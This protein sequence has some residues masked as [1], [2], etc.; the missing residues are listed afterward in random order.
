MLLGLN[1]KRLA[2]TA[3]VIGAIAYP[4]WTR[5]WTAWGSVISDIENSG[6]AILSHQEDEWAAAR[7]GVS[8]EQMRA[9]EIRKCEEHADNHRL[10][11]AAQQALDNVC[12]LR[13]AREL[14]PSI[15]KIWWLGIPRGLEHIGHWLIDAMLGSAVAAV[16]AY[17]GPGLLTNWWRWVRE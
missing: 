1:R 9:D 4:V 5:S 3:A 12:Y 6:W 17:F 16:I 10:S 2:I 14:P 7:L 15:F 8:V 13:P 11:V